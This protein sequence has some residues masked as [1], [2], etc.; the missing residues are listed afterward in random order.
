MS[1]SICR[2]RLLTSLLESVSWSLQSKYDEYVK[3]AVDLQSIGSS[4]NF[5]CVWEH[6]YN[7]SNLSNVDNTFGW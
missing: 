7:M 4:P 5:F 6:S 2:R 3:T 1:K